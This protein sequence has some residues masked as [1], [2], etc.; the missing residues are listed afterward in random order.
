MAQR[1]TEEGRTA[2]TVLDTMPI[3]RSLQGV[4][5]LA[6]LGGTNVRFALCQPDAPAPLLVQSIRP[7]RVADFAS[8]EAAATAYLQELQVGNVRHAVFAAAGRIAAGQVQLTNNAWRIDA[9]QLKQALQ[10]TSLQLVND[11]A[12][13]SMALPLLGDQD[14]V[15]LAGSLPDADCMQ[16]STTYCVLGPG[17]GLGV[18]ALRL[19]QGRPWVLQTEGG[20]T[21][22]APVTPLEVAILERLTRRFGRISNERLICGSGLVNLYQ[23]L[24]EISGIPTQDLTPEQVSARAASGADA[25]CQQA[26]ELF[27]AVLGSVAGDLALAYGA[28]DGVYLTGAWLRPLLPLL[29]QGL[30]HRRFVNKGRFEAAMQRIPVALIVHPQPGLLGAA[31]FALHQ[32]SQC[33]MRPCQPGLASQRS[34]GRQQRCSV[35]TT[36]DRMTCVG[37][38]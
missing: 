31:G 22:F 30:F 15:P 29:G 27:C 5:L 6:D 10:L 2:M 13:V 12:A 21:G 26:V 28:W 32:A 37:Q 19:E 4:R 24:C 3:D 23:A 7:Y 16:Y 34:V 38:K 33:S 20:H 8:L 14:V 25:K 1:W 18:G 36:I 35:E 9:A 11:F 17:T